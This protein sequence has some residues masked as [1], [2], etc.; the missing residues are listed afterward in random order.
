MK[1]RAISAAIV[2]GLSLTTPAYSADIS[3][4]DHIKLPPKS[5]PLAVKNTIIHGKSF[6][7]VKYLQDDHAV[8]SAVFDAAGK[9]V[10]E[11]SLPVVTAPLISPQLQKILEDTGDNDRPIQ[12]NV[13]LAL[14]TLT[15][16]SEPAWGGADV[17]GKD[18]S[19]HR[20]GELVSEESER[21]QYQADNAKVQ[22]ARRDR[23]AKIRHLSEALIQRNQWRQDNTLAEQLDRA[24]PT[25][26][27][28][29][30]KP[31]IERLAKT[32]PDL[33][34]GIEYYNKPQDGIAG[35]M[36]DTRIDPWA[37]NYGTRQGD[38]I[39]IYMTESGCADA[40]HI[41][42]YTRLSGPR[43]DHAENVSG[44]LRAASPL[45]HVYCR[46]GAVLP[47][48][49]DLDGSNGN[50]QVHIVTRSNGSP[51]SNNYSTQ[52]R[53]WDNLVYDDRVLTFLLAGNNGNDDD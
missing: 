48:A 16:P 27:L 30:T 15:T 52:D 1:I 32:S 36:Q 20:N 53:D 18:V 24:A 45:S 7:F 43:T 2:L 10:D 17:I 4:P 9:E 22:Q 35:A 51:G 31:Q 3:L 12:V 21:L 26:T 25:L 5:E 34:A 46:G 47:S 50:P 11:K 14:P 37:L 13:A 19:L 40:G 42:D 49:N 23:V 41:T 38:D 29:L 33:I 39:G 8:A 6:T 28:S 44:I